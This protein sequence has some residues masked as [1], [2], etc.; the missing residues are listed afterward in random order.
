MGWAV[1]DAESAELSAPLPPS[2]GQLRRTS[3]GAALALAHNMKET[4]AMNAQDEKKVVVE[5][6][7]MPVPND[8]PLVENLVRGDGLTVNLR[9]A[10]VT[11][12]DAWLQLDVS[13]AANAVDAFVRRRQNE[14][15]VVTPVTGKVA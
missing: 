10:R 2:F 4:N 3:I 1:P 9:R 12:R 11:S 8:R 15:T 14:F 5:F 6:F 7:V 13:G